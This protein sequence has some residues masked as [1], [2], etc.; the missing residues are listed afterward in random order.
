MAHICSQLNSWIPSLDK[1][2]GSGWRSA[3]GGVSLCDQS[4]N[5]RACESPDKG[6]TLPE[7]PAFVVH[8]NFQAVVKGGNP[9]QTGHSTQVFNLIDLSVETIECAAKKPLEVFTIDIRPMSEPDIDNMAAARTAWRRVMVVYAKW[10]S[11]VGEGAI[12]RSPPFLRCCQREAV[13][14]SM[15]TVDA[16]PRSFP[17]GYR[18]AL[19]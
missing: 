8:P 15:F 14:K 4:V 2:Y 7:L 9:C 16:D 10:I 13:H 18:L 3:F 17:G 19:L 1:V 12:W 11:L 6:V 5:S